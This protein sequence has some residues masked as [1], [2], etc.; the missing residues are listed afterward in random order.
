MKKLFYYIL[1]LFIFSQCSTTSIPHI[2]NFTDET[3]TFNLQCLNND[4]LF[5][6]YFKMMQ[7]KDTLNTHAFEEGVELKLIKEDTYR[8]STQLKPYSIFLL[9][10]PF[11]WKDPKQ[12]IITI[13]HPNGEIETL[14]QEKY[15]IVD[16]E[17]KKLEKSSPR[18]FTED[19]VYFDVR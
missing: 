6:Q 19:K 5:D 2:R 1:V 9:Y 12:Y 16:K 15:S 8:I 14:T 4:S 10:R 18:N 13:T 7:I 17:G 3:L 11:S